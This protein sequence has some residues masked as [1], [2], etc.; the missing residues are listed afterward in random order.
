MIRSELDHA[1]L[2]G[3]VRKTA[4][5][6]RVPE[7][8]YVRWRFE[9]PAHGLP[10]NEDVFI[11]ILEGAMNQR[12]AVHRNWSGGQLLDIIQIV[13]P[14]LLARPLRREL[15]HGIEI[16][17]VSKPRDG[18]VVIAPNDDRRKLLHALGHFVWIGSVIDDVTQAE[19]AFPTVLHCVEGGIERSG[20][21]MNI[22]QQ[23]KSHR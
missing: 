23:E 10:R 22:T 20:I 16:F 2:P 18:F 8:C 1:N 3:A 19:D 4:L 7:K 14:H 5:M 12:N 21:G 13:R 6:M 15:R 9:K 17:K 11:L